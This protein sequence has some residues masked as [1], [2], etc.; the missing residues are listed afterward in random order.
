MQPFDKHTADSGALQGC[1]AGLADHAAGALTT[2]GLTQRAYAPAVA[3]WSGLCAP[4][5]AAAPAPLAASAQAMS[6]ALTWAGVVRHFWARQVTL[7]N[8]RVD[9][10]VAHLHSL[11]PTFGA[12]GADG[13]PP[14]ADDVAAA[15][16]VATNAAKRLW[17]D[18]YDTYI[19][20]GGD[21]T[22][23]ML[24]QGPTL[25]NIRDIGDSGIGP[26]VQRF[27]NRG[28]T[29]SG[30][31]G[32]FGPSPL[33]LLVTLPFDVTGPHAGADADA[34][35]RSQDGSVGPHASA[36]VEANLL[37]LRRQF[38]DAMSTVDVTGTV[39]AH[40][41][42]EARAEAGP[43]GLHA[44]A[45]VDAEAGAKVSVGGTLGTPKGI[46]FTPTIDGRAGVSVD[47]GGGVDVDEDGIHID[48]HAGGSVGLGGGAHLETTVDVGGLIQSVRDAPRNIDKIV[49]IL[50]G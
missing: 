45:G 36:S 46:Q 47:A 34:G 8:Q 3:N 31:F 28:F 40:A 14:E 17:W 16:A 29:P 19:D 39:G 13:K 2:A 50:G 12:H 24:R 48:V 44:H 9:E 15:R 22:A 5:L 33:F 7:F 20:G 37:E 30:P 6:A 25:R 26:E 23:A 10:I 11:G 1:G 21:R 49:D 27:L 43:N 38:R 18:A 42:A 41:G 35:L 4:Q 32:P